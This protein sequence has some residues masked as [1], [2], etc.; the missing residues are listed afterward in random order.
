MIGGMDAVDNM[1]KVS[2]T[3]KGGNPDVPVTDVL[4]QSATQ[5]Q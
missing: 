2:T 4:I 5:N 3:T 1:A